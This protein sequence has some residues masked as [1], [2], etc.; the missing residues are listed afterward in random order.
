MKESPPFAYLGIKLGI[1][2]RQHLH[3]TDVWGL[4]AKSPFAEHHA[5]IQEDTQK[6][7]NAGNKPFF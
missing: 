2:P 7:Q 1:N 3:C 6:P 4:K 5:N